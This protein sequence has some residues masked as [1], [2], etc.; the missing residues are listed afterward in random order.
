MELAPPDE[1]RARC[2]AR[3]RA[4]RG[5][6]CS[7]ARA[8]AADWLAE[9]AALI[10]A[11]PALRDDV[12]ARGAARRAAHVPA[13]RAGRLRAAGARVALARERGAAG[14][15]PFALFYLGMGA[16]GSRRWAE[17]AAHFEE[18]LRLAGETGLRVDAVTCS[19][20]S[21]GSRRA[22]ATPRPPSTP[23]TRSARRASSA[24]R[25]SRPGRCTPRATSRWARGALPAARRRV[26]GEA[27]VLDDARHRATPT[28]RRARAGRAARPARAPG[29]GGRAGRA[30]AGEAG[31]KGRPWALARAHRAD[32]L[33]PTTPRPSA[34]TPRRSRCTRTTDAFERAR[35]ELCLG[36]RLRRAGRRADA[37]EPLRA[38]L[39]DL[40]RARRRAVGRARERRAEGDRRD[41]PPPRRRV[42]RRA[43]AAGAA[44]RADARRRR[45]PRGRPRRRSTSA[46]RPSST[47]CATSTSSSASTRAPRWRRRSGPAGAGPESNE[48]PTR[49]LP[50]RG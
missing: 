4:G 7:A 20:G 41:R 28:C 50:A 44:D 23:P 30:L 10:E 42:A 35:T 25:S 14:V 26:R 39:A 46:R 45:R 22:A 34:T 1:P 17:A 33:R 5:A 32:A 31:R 29:R 27:R 3:D 38:A 40:R 12:R 6:T 15:L 13:H 47:T 24:C 21:R 2:L 8:E 11:T 36:E 49:A 18:G 9:A 19:P 16:F 37:R 48:A 43:D